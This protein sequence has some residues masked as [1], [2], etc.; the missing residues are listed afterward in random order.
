MKNTL[1]GVDCRITKA[2]KQVSELEDRM[3]TITSAEYNKEKRMKR[4]Q[5]SL[6][7]HQDDS[8]HTNIHN[9]GVPEK[10]KEKKQPEKTLEEIIAE[11]FPNMGNEAVTQIY[12]VQRVP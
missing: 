2:E 11:K 3:G 6:G 4:N 9:I 10:E 8:K 7:D 5:D 1:K 12:E